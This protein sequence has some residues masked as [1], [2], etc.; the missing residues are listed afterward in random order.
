MRERG[1]RRETGGGRNPMDAIEGL[2]GWISLFFSTDKSGGINRL[3][4]PL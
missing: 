3:I 2:K 4:H 1:D